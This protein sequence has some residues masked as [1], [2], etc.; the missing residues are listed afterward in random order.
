VAVARDF[1]GRARSDG[2]NGSTNKITMG[3]VPM[4]AGLLA[5]AAP[6]GSSHGHPVGMAKALVQ[7]GPASQDWAYALAI[8]RD[9][10]LVAAG[11]SAHGHWRFA[12]ARFTAKGRLD[13]TF[14]RGG[15][16]LT[17]FGSFGRS[18]ASAL[19]IQ[20]DG[21]LVAAGRTGVSALYDR[22]AVGRY[23]VRGSLDRS[24]GRGGKVLMNLGSTK[25][26][27]AW[28]RAVAIQAD[29]K[30]VVA[31]GSGTVL[32]CGRFA[33]GRYLASG[34]RDRSFGRDGKVV[35]RLS[36][37]GDAWALAIQRDGRIVAAGTALASQRDEFALAR[38]TPRGR[39]DSSFGHDGTVQTGVGSWSQAKA[40]AIQRDGMIVVGGRSG[41]SDFGLARYNVDGALDPNFG[42]GG[43]VVTNFGFVG[44]PPGT[45]ASDDEAEAIAI[46]ADGKIVVAGFSDARG[47]YGERTGCCI[48][49][50]ALARYLPDGHLDP[51]F[52]SG[53]KVLTHFVRNSYA[54]AV[55]IQADGKIVA[56]GGSASY[57]ALARYTSSGS[58]DP[59]FGR[60]GKVLMHFR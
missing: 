58:L 50:F 14:G 52:G 34:I 10:R 16:V 36:A 11:R 29:D 47:Q 12:L 40:V 17:E 33:L 53:G 13:P 21:R 19:A 25:R 30:L 32:C 54:Q 35:T 44:S 23:T 59:T 7:R 41:Y 28:A 8:Q 26:V 38:Y 39:L 3:L 5:L 49:D 22:V 18:T 20:R 15:K 27:S 48:S 31:G 6:D 37:D 60:G 24:F 51:Q 1:L 57:F 46:Q 43:E 56:V 42:S 2:L 55:Q 45:S 9:G 4:A